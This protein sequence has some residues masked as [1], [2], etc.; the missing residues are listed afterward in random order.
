MDYKVDLE[1]VKKVLDNINQTVLGSL[2]TVNNLEI[3]FFAL[4][5]FRTS[6]SLKTIDDGDVLSWSIKNT[7]DNYKY[8]ISKYN[9]TDVE[10]E[11]DFAHKEYL[12][13]SDFARYTDTSLTFEQRFYLSEEKDAIE[14]GQRRI[15]YNTLSRSDI[16][17]KGKLSLAEY[18]MGARVIVNLHG[19]FSRLGDSESNQVMGSVS[20]V[21]RSGET[22]DITIT[23]QGGAIFNK[24]AIITDD[25]RPD[26]SSASEEDRLYSS[27]IMGE[28]S[29]ISQKNDLLGCNCI[30]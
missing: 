14:C 26:F 28:N 19:L 20:S 30:A 15:F 2:V 21:K 23:T 3:A 24:N 18:E 6:Q 8:L 10:G 27:Y 29:T 16:I 13:T 9:Y 11:D 12:Y 4:D 5:V 25:S 1:E 7:G 17:I 22:V